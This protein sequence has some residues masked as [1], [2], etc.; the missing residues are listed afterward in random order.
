ML[1]LI[2][3]RNNKKGFTLA[4]LLIV[5]A[6]IA[7][8]VAIS[9]PIFTSQLRK[10]KVSTDLANIRAAKAA[11]AS[12]YLTSDQTGT[13]SYNYDAAK[14]VVY[15]STDSAHGA[16]TIEAYGKTTDPK[17]ADGFASNDDKTHVGKIVQI[18]ITG[19]DKNNAETTYSWTEGKQ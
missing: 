2:Q 17:T 10:A 16:A 9:I 1:K 8:L 11:A 15:Q 4:E 3:K 19:E 6:I 13:I 5:V 14:G 18:T 7:V 12:E